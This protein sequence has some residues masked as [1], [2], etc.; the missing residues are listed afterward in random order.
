MDFKV[1]LPGLAPIP[2]VVSV[3]LPAPIIL[4]KPESFNVPI[5]LPLPVVIAPSIPVELKPIKK[6]EEPTL[7]SFKVPEVAPK[8]INIEI[9]PVPKNDPV[10]KSDKFYL[11]GYSKEEIPDDSI[12]I[13]ANHS[14]IEDAITN[15]YA[16]K[17]AAGQQIYICCYQQKN[18]TVS[19]TVRVIEDGV[20]YACFINIY[21]DKC[22]GCCQIKLDAATSLLMAKATCRGGVHALQA[23]FDKLRQLGKEDVA[24]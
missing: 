14:A 19:M 18:I 5:L 21:G 24:N 7:I 9:T 1:E 11:G 15:W 17:D 8:K 6:K 22:I 4:P 10:D 3:Q 16:S 2:P 23:I 12:R 20:K 13:P